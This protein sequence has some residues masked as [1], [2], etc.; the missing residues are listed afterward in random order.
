VISFR[1]FLVL[2]ILGRLPGAA[3]SAFAA[4]GLIGAPPPVWLTATAA[5]VAGGILAVVYRS[6]LRAWFIE[7][8]TRSV[9]D[10]A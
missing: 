8:V 10:E 1:R 4:A 9:P 7:K 2:S 5:A 6:R 3:F